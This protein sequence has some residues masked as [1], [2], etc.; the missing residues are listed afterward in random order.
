[1]H[2]FQLASIDQILTKGI[3]LAEAEP[4][5]F[6]TTDTQKSMPKINLLPKVKEISE[7]EEIIPKNE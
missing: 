4:I 5:A 2:H 1:M 3:A 6:T 7:V